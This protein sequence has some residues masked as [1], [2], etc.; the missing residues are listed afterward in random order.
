MYFTYNQCE[1]FFEEQAELWPIPRE[2]RAG[3]WPIPLERA[4][5]FIVNVILLTGGP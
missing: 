1:L 3:L 2:E 4:H 5:M